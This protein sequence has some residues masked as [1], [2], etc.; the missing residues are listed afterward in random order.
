MARQTQMYRTPCAAKNPPVGPQ[1]MNPKTDR[2][3]N[4][5][6]E[7]EGTGSCRGLNGANRSLNDWRL[8]HLAREQGFE[9]HS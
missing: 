7:S 2:A 5:G 3:G 4:K 8:G 9:H 1:H 6:R